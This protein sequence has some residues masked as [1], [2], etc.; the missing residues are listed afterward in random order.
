MR[1]NMLYNPSIYQLRELQLKRMLS[2][3]E[4]NRCCKENGVLFIGDSITEFMDIANYFPFI[5]N[6]N[7]CGIAGITSKALLWFVDEGV[8]KYK[9][10]HVVLMVGTNDLGNTLMSSPREIALNIKSF[11]EIIFRNLKDIKVTII[12][13]LPCDEALHGDRNG[14]GCRNNYSLS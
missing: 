4:G 3:I 5:N 8:I 14:G 6:F 10:N 13:P 9:P 7:N 2:I 1:E 12:S 11:V